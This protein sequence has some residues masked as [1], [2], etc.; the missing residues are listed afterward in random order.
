MVD[1]FERF[2][3]YIS[4]VSKYW[5]K[6]AGDE[7]VKYGL[8]GPHARYLLAIANYEDGITAPQLCEVCGKDKADV[9]RMI[10]IMEK[11]GLV[12][13]EGVHQ[14]MYRGVLKLTDKGK[15]AAEHVQQRASLAVELAGKD[16]S[17]EKRAVFYE[18]LESIA[19]NLREISQEGLP[20]D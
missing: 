2:S 9:S 11:E 10:S 20:E 1:R 8:K 6:I 7:M 17:E 13:K 15:E 4:E 16:L 19:L 18:A 14:N 5:H 3:Y 12:K